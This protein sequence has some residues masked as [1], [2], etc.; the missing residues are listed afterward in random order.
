MD[1]I[2]FKEM[3]AGSIYQTVLMIRE[4]T[5]KKDKNGRAYL[6]LK[7][8]DGEMEADMFLWEMTAADFPLAPGAVI[9]AT[10]A[11][12]LYND[13][14]SYSLKSYQAA[15][16]VAVSEFIPSAPVS[17]EVLYGHCMEAI[18]SIAE[19]GF[20]D[21]TKAIFEDHRE[22]LLW[23]S[24]AKS[25]HHNRTG[26]LLWHVT[27][28]MRM[29]EA[30]AREYENVNRGLLIAG[31]LLHDI[32]KLSELNTSSLGITDYTV[33]GELCGHAYLGAEMI[34][35]YGKKLG[36][37]VE[38]VRMLVHIILSHHGKPEYGAVTRP[39]TVEAAIVHFLDMLDSHVY[40]YEKELE[41]LE[42][43]ESTDPIF[44][45]DGARVYKPHPLS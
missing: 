44:F 35:T 6:I 26:E 15:K 37:P 18:D 42:A 32:G 43:G 34:R 19:K 41:K 38:D 4:I 20:R 25:V 9:D 21:L 16:G 14:F 28:M 24:A 30:A 8:G 22:K 1:R 36:T 31:I 27:R 11:V 2:K 7:M 29:A 33:A 40:I 12:S 5:E 13:K 39:S 23:W 3:K 45:L 17:P 10:V